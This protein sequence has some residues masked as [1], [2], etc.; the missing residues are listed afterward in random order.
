[1]SALALH[2]LST[3]TENLGMWQNQQFDQLVQQAE[4]SSSGERL[5][6]YAQAEQIAIMEVGWLP[7]YHQT[8]A[9]IIPATVHGV[10]LNHMGLYFGDWSDVYLTSR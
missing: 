2:L 1:M 6:L 7:L 9:A 4:Q 10:S 5:D 8:L 3:S